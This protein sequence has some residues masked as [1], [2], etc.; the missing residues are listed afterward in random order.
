MRIGNNPSIVS[1]ARR[2]FEM[3]LQP[4]RAFPHET[5]WIQE[6]AKTYLPSEAGFSYSPEHLRSA[7]ISLV[8]LRNVLRRGHVTQVNNLNRPGAL[9]IVEGDNNDGERFRLTV[10]VISESIAV[11]LVRGER[12]Q[13]QG[14]ENGHDA[15]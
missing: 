6:F 8:G 2:L 15:A 1:D 3:P 10:I 13:V 11:S 9:W 12:V 14:E 7:G 4:K 5:S